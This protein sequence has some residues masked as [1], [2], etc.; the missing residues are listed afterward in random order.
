MD[1][2]SDLR[3]YDEAKKWAEEFAKT[4]GENSQVQ[5]L[6]NKQAEWSEEVKNYDAA[7]EMYIKVGSPRDEGAKLPEGRGASRVCTPG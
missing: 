1:M 6:I 2:F 7:A 5:E 3:Q 4:R